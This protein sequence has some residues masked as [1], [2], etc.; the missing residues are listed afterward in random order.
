MFAASTNKSETEKPKVS[1]DQYSSAKKTSPQ[2]MN[3]APTTASPPVTED[4]SSE[5]DKK[6]K[7]ELHKELLDTLGQSNVKDGSDSSSEESGKK[8]LLS[9]QFSVSFG[10]PKGPINKY[11]CVVYSTN[12]TK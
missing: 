11:G 7:T 1:I 6:P 2:K 4:L 9:R 12:F 10:F 3:F 5:G 8:R